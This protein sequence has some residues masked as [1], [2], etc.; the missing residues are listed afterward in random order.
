MPF[1]FSTK[2]KN[3]LARVLPGKHCCLTAELAALIGTAG[4]FNFDN[5]EDPILLLQTEN[6]AV[7]RKVYRLFKALYKINPQL[8]VL[9]QNRLKKHALYRL[10]V[11]V[12]ELP[13]ILRGEHDQVLQPAYRNLVRRRCCQKA[14]LRGTFLATGSVSNPEKDYHLE[15]LVRDELKAGLVCTIMEEF[16]LHPKVIKRKG[17]L[18]IYLKNSNEIG[19]FLR[20]TGASRAILDFENTRV[21]RQVKNGVN[22]VVN[23]ETANLNKSVDTGVR[24]AEDIIF[25]KQRLELD[26]LPRALRET[27]ALRLE[28]PQASLKELGEALDLSKSGVNHRLRRLAELAEKLREG[29]ERG[30]AP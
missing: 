5:P 1:S 30:A 14:F 6:A 13:D 28:N 3:E 9:R 11:S 23:C 8:K 2:T 24:Q 10:K 15:L 17:E 22:R 21:V 29:S 25:L 4:R 26:K 27:A 18:M 20:L 12:R 19:D 16:H 7:A